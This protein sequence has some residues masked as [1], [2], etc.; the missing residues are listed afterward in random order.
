MHRMV[1]AGV[2]KALTTFCPLEREDDPIFIL[3]ENV[4]CRH[5]D[6]VGKK[7]HVNVWY[8]SAL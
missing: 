6:A 5:V 4:S 3:L 7:E 2:P 8:P 1:G